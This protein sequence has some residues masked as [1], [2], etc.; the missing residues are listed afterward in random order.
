MSGAGT[1]AVTVTRSRGHI[2][3]DKDGG[4]ALVCSDL[5]PVLHLWQY[6]G[7][8]NLTPDAARAFAS[9]L[10]EWADEA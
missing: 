3:I 9:A 7:E 5:G 10:N 2:R 8:L 4:A 6:L 1:P